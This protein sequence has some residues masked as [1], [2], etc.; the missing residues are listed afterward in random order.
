MLTLY[1]GYSQEEKIKLYELNHYLR[2]LYLKHSQYLKKTLNT[3][4]LNINLT[5]EQSLILRRDLIKESK[6]YLSYLRKYKGFLKNLPNKFHDFDLYE[7]NQLLLF[8]LLNSSL[9]TSLKVNLLILNKVSFFFIFF[10]WHF[11][12]IFFFSSIFSLKICEKFLSR[13]LNHWRI[14]RFQLDTLPVSYAV[15]S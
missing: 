4:N 3:N 11:F 8:D 1:K 2:S 10:N 7:N 9:F 12:F 14:Q 6:S 15:L 5:F 13:F